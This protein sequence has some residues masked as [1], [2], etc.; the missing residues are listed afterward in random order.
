VG[1]I[2]FHVRDV[3]L[4]PLLAPD[5]FE[6]EID[7]CE[8]R[9]GGEAG[10]AQAGAPRRLRKPSALSAQAG[11]CAATNSPTIM[12]AEKAAAMILEDRRQEDETITTIVS[13]G[14]PMPHR[15]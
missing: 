7:C 2:I 14:F 10:F 8:M 3:V 5:G 15:S 6:A 9:R 13:R 1:W 12:I 4:R 11:G